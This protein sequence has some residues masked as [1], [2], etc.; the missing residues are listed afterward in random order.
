M[1]VSLKWLR[2]YVDIDQDAKAVADYL[3]MAGLEVDAIEDAG[4][5]FEG[6]VVARILSVKSHPAADKLHLCDVSIGDQVLPVVCGAP[7]TRAGDNVALAK[8]GATIPGGYVIKASRLRGELSE[9]MLCSEEE[10]GIGDDNQGIMILPPDLPL[11]IDLKEA[12]HLNDYVLDVSIT[13]NR[14]DCLSVIGIAREIAALTGKTLRHP[15]IEIVEN[16]EDI[17]DKTSVT[18]NDADLCPR[19]SA[20]MIKNISIKPS[21]AWMRERLEAVGMRAINNIVD[22]TNFVMLEM[23]QP[24]HA[25]DFRFLEEGRIV[26]RRSLEGEHFVSLDEKDRLLKA[27]TLMICDGV[28]PVAIAG[29]MGGLNSEVKDDTD[30]ILLESAYFHPPSIR[31]SARWLG[32]GTDAAYRFERGVDPEGVIRAL[33]RAAQLMAE[34]GDGVVCKN[35]IDQYPRNIEAVKDIPLRVQRVNDILGTRITPGEIQGILEK[36]EMIMQPVQEGA[37]LVTPPTFRV[38]INR[39]IDLVEEIAR[40]YGYD[41]VPVTMPASSGMPQ[42]P[43]KKQIIEKK[44]RDIM[45]GFGFSE[46]ITYSFVPSSFPAV[47]GLTHEAE[48]SHLIRIRNPLTE[49]Q[50][51]MRTTLLY[52]LLDTMVK[53]GRSGVYDL[54]IFEIG[55]VYFAG[56]E[57]Q[58]PVEKNH[59]GCLLKGLRY[60][61][62][63]H[64]PGL[65]ADYY[66]LKGVVEHVM[67]D[68]KLAGLRFSPDA[69]WPF[70]HPGRSCRIHIGDD[71]IGFMGEVHPH[72]LEAMALRNR[73]VVFELDMDLIMKHC[74]DSSTGFKE[75]SKFPASSRDVAFVVSQ[76]VDAQR[77]LDAA[78]RQGEELLEKVYI[79]DVYTGENIPEG[80]KSLGLRFSYRSW[81]RTL[82]DEDVNNSHG[83]IVKDVIKE[84]QAKIRE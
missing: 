81:D 80:T 50:A 40:L 48:A 68:L 6:V 1:K 41:R 79:F 39:E 44:L 43:P 66:D 7:N 51:V 25:F 62:S 70:L 75:V 38:D 55:R 78:F 67:A 52:N 73:A 64:M 84:T 45:T 28:K 83:R 49:D 35:Y 58:L 10:L 23:G 46:V 17:K 34:L 11:G 3:T 15:K 4:P 76:E 61:D 22:I 33:N 31:R 72:I 60:N 24:L 57:G 29:I 82:T 16:D 69:P 27:D 8:V 47:L 36:L 26:V 21:P 53:N 13:P 59:I 63:W 5:A 2:D 37:Y 74:N 54:K 56:K 14:A 42:R 77:L 32:M 20:R 71:T 12:L 30:T 18:I 9:G 65:Q 19:Y